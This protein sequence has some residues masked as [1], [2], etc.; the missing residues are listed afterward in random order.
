MNDDLT[1][2]ASAYLDG[3]ATP[4][5]RARVEADPAL[6][7]EVERLRAVRVTLLDARWFEGPSDDVREAA[8]AAA[9]GALDV[10]DVDLSGATSRNSAGRPPIK[11]QDVRTTPHVHALAQRRGRPRRRRRARCRRGPVRRWRRRRR[12]R[13]PWRSRRRPTPR[14]GD[15]LVDTADEQRRTVRLDRQR[16]ADSRAPTTT[17][18]PTPAAPSLPPSSRRASA[19]RP[20]R[21]RR[22]RPRQSS[23]TRRRRRSC[24]PLQS[25]AAVRRRGQAPPPTNDPIA[26][27]L[28]RPCSDDAFDDIDTYV[29]IGHVSRPVGADRHR[30]RATT[31]RSPST[32]TRA[33]SWPKHL[34]PD[35]ANV[36]TAC[37]ATR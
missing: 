18:A 24:R 25:S 26:T 5:E 30:R 22:P 31:G 13:A 34:C 11:R 35:P 2:L 21:R 32:L 8:I 1:L 12:V 9:L 16:R 28:A 27:S 3:E 29:A 7:G 14:R 19:V 15:A 10:A 33:R 20:P 4:D 36:P 17:P 37:R 6:L 23:P